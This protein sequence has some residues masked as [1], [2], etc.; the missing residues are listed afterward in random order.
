[1]KYPP[2]FRFS[3]AEPS[4]SK[5]DNIWTLGD[6]GPSQKSDITI[7]GT[8]EGENS[9]ERTFAAS[10]G[11]TGDDGSLKPF[12]TASEKVAI[13]NLRLICRF[14][15]TERKTPPASLMPEK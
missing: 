9:E 14:S 5:G 7:E 12:G 15:S 11:T 3:G 1:M 13:K 6:I 8:I 2:G 4:P 10:V